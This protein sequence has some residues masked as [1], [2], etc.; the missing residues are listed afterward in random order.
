MIESSR[1]FLVPFQFNDSNELA[2]AVRESLA[3]I[4]PWQPWAI[5][6]YGLRH[7][8]D[9]IATSSKQH[10]SKTNLVFA[11]KRKD[12][13][14]VGCINLQ[15]QPDLFGRVIPAF[16]VGFWVRTSDTSHGYATEA[17]QRI[18]RYAFEEGA[19]HR[20]AVRCH[21][22]NAASARVAQKAGFQLEARLKHTRRNPDDTLADT[23]IFAQTR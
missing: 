19:A 6:D 4:S 21:S 3:E 8:Q 5:S 13:H 22:S 11:V 23:L 15:P 2:R 17:L 1:L 7:S 14:L 9:F 16:E 20:V 10:L 18:T 12:G